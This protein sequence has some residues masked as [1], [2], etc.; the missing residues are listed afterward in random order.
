VST[1]DNNSQPDTTDLK[2]SQPIG[3]GTSEGR[4]RLLRAG[5]M[6]APALLALKSAPVLAC[7]CK[8]P[9]G[10]SAS[11]NLSRTGATNCSDRAPRPSEWPG[12]CNSSTKKYGT[13][14]VKS[15]ESLVTNYQF[16]AGG[17][18]LAATTI[19]QA[20]V[21]GSNEKVN[22]IA[23]AFLNVRTGNFPSGITEAN[24]RAMWSGLLN[25]GYKPNAASSVVWNQDQIL[26]YLRY[27]MG[28]A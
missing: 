9:S 2:P 25:G 15:S 11:G 24:V 6:G 20:L 22:L 10:F 4:R 27:V 5:L 14:S 3:R 21:M 16:A 7:N 12:K 17:G 19:G 26:K 23:A 13:S 28:L 1:P 18:L 8:L